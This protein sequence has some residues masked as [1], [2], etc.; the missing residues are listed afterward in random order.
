MA[1]ATILT[2]V[3][4]AVANAVVFDRGNYLFGSLGCDPSAS[5]ERERHEKA[6]EQIQTAQAAWS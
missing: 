1:V 5:I 3:G 2:L 4:G 6:L